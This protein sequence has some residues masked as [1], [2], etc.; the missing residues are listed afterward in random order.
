[1]SRSGSKK[2]YTFA[3]TEVS[4]LPDLGA[5]Y[6]VWAR[7][8]GTSGGSDAN[9]TW[10]NAP[11]PRPGDDRSVRSSAPAK[12][13]CNHS[14]VAPKDVPVRPPWYPHSESSKYAA[15][16][17][18]TVRRQLSALAVRQSGFAPPNKF[19]Q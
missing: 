10:T 13:V 15:D 3:G 4:S 6:T 7:A 12:E 16:T 8:D 19:T 17:V 5:E 18:S 11:K 9:S 1:M 14:I 2:Y